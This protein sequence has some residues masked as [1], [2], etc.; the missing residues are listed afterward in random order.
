MAEVIPADLPENSP[1]PP[2]GGH[3]G[4]D[5]GGRPPQAA[6]DNDESFFF[7]LPK[8]ENRHFN[9]LLTLQTSKLYIL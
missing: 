4:E 5:P 2:P 7:K 9:E 6:F 3:P 8:A 1:E